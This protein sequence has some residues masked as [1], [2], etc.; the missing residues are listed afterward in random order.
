[1]R[2]PSSGESTY[3]LF[4]ELMHRLADTG[5]RTRGEKLLDGESVELVRA[6]TELAGHFDGPLLAEHVPDFIDP[7]RAQQASHAGLAAATGELNSRA[8]EYPHVA[9][10]KPL[11]QQRLEC[12]ADQIG[13]ADRA[14]SPLGILSGQSR[15]RTLFHF[16]TTRLRQFLKQY[17]DRALAVGGEP[18]ARGQLLRRGE[19]GLQA[20]G[21]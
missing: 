13:R 14:D 17:P 4:G 11:L 10:A 20:L 5:C 6:L 12:R 2:A 8:L 3:W 9:L 19:V 1:M 16:R 7:E 21:Q 18:Q 15:G